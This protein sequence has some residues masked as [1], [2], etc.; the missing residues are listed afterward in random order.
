MP[1]TRAEAIKRATLAEVISKLKRAERL[2]KD[3]DCPELARCVSRRLKVL[4]AE[5]ADDRF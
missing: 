5:Y 2:L 3:T 1:I 4:E